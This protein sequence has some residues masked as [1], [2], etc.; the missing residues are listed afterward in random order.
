MLHVKK[1]SGD[2][3]LEKRPSDDVQISQKELESLHEV[4]NFDA[5]NEKISSKIL[6]DILSHEEDSVGGL[7]DDKKL[8]KRLQKK[9]FAASFTLQ[10]VR[11]E[12]LFLFLDF[13]RYAFVQC[14]TGDARIDD[15]QLSLTG[16]HT[17][18]LQSFSTFSTS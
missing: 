12:M 16:E 1:E 5:V 13:V 6:R 14:M 11:D 18:L 15:F 8:V 9:V 4:E 3:K 17:V 7:S 2:S 10:Q